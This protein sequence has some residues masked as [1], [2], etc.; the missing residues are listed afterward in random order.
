MGSQELGSGFIR[1]C[2]LGV[3]SCFYVTG[4]YKNIGKNQSNQIYI[5]PANRQF[6]VDIIVK[7]H[8]IWWHKQLFGMYCIRYKQG[9]CM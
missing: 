5:S 1:T 7:E 8:T 3:Q 4:T 6:M 9:G 2:P